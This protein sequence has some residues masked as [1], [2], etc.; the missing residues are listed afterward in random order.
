MSWKAGLYNYSVDFQLFATE[1][2]GKYKEIN[3]ESKMS[4]IYEFSLIF[5]HLNRNLKTVF[6]AVIAV[7][8]GKEYFKV[9]TKI[10]L[11]LLL[12]V[13][14]KKRVAGQ[15]GDKLIESYNEQPTIEKQFESSSII[16]WFMNLAQVNSGQFN[17]FLKMSL[18]ISLACV[19]SKTHNLQRVFRPG[20]VVPYVGY[21]GMCRPKGYVFFSR[22][23]LK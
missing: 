2:F 11:F 14:R 20:G 3:D 7:S 16:R 5:I 17:L 1:S 6:Y 10:G 12:S 13:W 4:K 8:C 22:F 18:I 9:F 15:E 19:S 21:T 23:G